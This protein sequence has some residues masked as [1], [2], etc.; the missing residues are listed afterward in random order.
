[1]CLK[2]L[3]GDIIK[4]VAASFIFNNVE[5]KDLIEKYL[6][7]KEELLKVRVFG[8]KNM[9]KYGVGILNR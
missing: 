9:A 8:T 3:R 7:T 2:E 4:N 1:M 5:L 6:R